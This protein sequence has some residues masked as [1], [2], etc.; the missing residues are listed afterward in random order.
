MRAE[1]IA[2]LHE[3]ALSYVRA[4][5]DAGCDKQLFPDGL[6][7]RFAA[8]SPLVRVAEGTPPELVDETVRVV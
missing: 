6:L 2:Y 3:D 1:L 7:L 8:D 5:A 4:G